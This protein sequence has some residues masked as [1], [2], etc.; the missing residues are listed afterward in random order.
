MDLDTLSLFVHVVQ[1]GSFAAAARDRNLDPSSVS[2]TIAGLEAALNVRLLQRTTRAMVLTEAGEQYFARIQ[3]LLEELARVHDDTTSMRADPLGTLRLTASVSFGDTCLIPLLPAFQEAFP[4]LHL[5]LI[6]TDKTLD[7]VAERI[8]LA[9]RLAPSYRAD[10]IGTKL[11]P[12]R[13]RVV[14]SPAYVRRTETLH[15][16]SDLDAHACL[17]FSLPDFRTRWLFR[18]HGAII[19]QPVRGTLILSNAL[20]LRSAALAGLGPTLLPDWLIGHALAAGDLV[21]VFPDYDVAATTFETAAWLL[22]PSR[23][24]LPIK[25]RATIDFLKKH[26]GP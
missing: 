13:Y 3:P 18:R 24:Y 5:E 10:V 8:D 16:P 19:E 26:C 2:R 6:L 22:Y 11:F 7:L 4:R 14:A 20:A 9:I 12:T 25:V 15:V 17:L 21:D 1:R 23:A